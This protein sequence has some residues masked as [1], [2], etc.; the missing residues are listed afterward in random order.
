MQGAGRQGC[1]PRI[2][3]SRISHFEQ[4]RAG[5]HH[6]GPAIGQASVNPLLYLGF[7]LIGGK[8]RPVCLPGHSRP[9]SV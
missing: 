5:E 7:D 2:H 6:S 3:G 8:R 4:G 9:R 1:R